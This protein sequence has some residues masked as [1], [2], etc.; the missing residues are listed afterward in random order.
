MIHAWRM[1]NAK[2]ADGRK[3]LEQAGALMRR[4]IA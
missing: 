3:A 1:R 4:W 2:L